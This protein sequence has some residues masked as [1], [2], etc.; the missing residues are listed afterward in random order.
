MLKILCGPI[1][2]THLPVSVWDQVLR[3]LITHIIIIQVSLTY[4]EAYQFQLQQV[5]A[6]GGHIILPEPLG[7]L[8]TPCIQYW[9]EKA[10]GVGK[11]C[12][13][14]EVLFGNYWLLSL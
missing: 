8:W 1:I 12:K 5:Q 14:V 13:L 7:P 9:Q 11:V 6:M 2:T 3:Y 10:R 4:L